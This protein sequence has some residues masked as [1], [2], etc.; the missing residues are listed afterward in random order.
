MSYYVPRGRMSAIG[1]LSIVRKDIR[2]K[3]ISVVKVQCKELKLHK[4]WA[5]SGRI[6]PTYILQTYINKLVTRFWNDTLASGIFKSFLS[7]KV[8][9]MYTIAASAQQRN[10]GRELIEDDFVMHHDMWLAGG[11]RAPAIRRHGPLTR[12]VKLQVAHVPGTFSP[13]PQVSDPDMHHG[14]CVTHVPWCLLGSITSG[15]F[16]CRWRGKRPWHSLRMRN[17]HFYV[18]GKWSMAQFNRLLGTYP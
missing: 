14:T 11:S 16:S 5:I 12:Y 1:A 15:F 6:L 8:H 3:I 17:P 13:P 4:K 9:G 18:Y 2:C 10:R 7:K